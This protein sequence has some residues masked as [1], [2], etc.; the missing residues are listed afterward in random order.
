MPQITGRAVHG[1]GRGKGQGLDV[2]RLSRAQGSV[3]LT[4]NDPERYRPE[5]LSALSGRLI[6]Q[7]RFLSNAQQCSAIAGSLAPAIRVGACMLHAH[8][9]CRVLTKCFRM[10]PTK[11]T[12]WRIGYCNPPLQPAKASKLRTP[13]SRTNVI[14]VARRG[15]AFRPMQLTSCSP[16]YKAGH[17]GELAAR[18]PPPTPAPASRISSRTQDKSRK[19]PPLRR[20]RTY[21]PRDRQSPSYSM[22][23]RNVT[24]PKELELELRATSSPQ[25]HAREPHGARRIVYACQLEQQSKLARNWGKH[26]DVVAGIPNHRSFRR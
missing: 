12:E 16:W 3:G 26:H 10:F 7:S 18:D 8:G 1:H 6:L 22:P 23:I 4:C 9:C 5:R 21:L 17:I 13:R 25:V 24:K 14:V 15:S 2:E 11:C 19:C 20:P